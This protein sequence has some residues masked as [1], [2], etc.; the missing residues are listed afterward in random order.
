MQAMQFLFN[1][2][3]GALSVIFILRMWFQYCQV[4]F[5]LPLSQ[6]L[7]KWT[8]PVIKPLSRFLPTV[9]RINLPALLVVFLLGFLKLPLLSFAFDGNNIL[10]YAWVGLLHIASI[11]GETILYILFFGAILSWFNRSDNSLQIILYQLS[12]PLLNPIRRI[13]PHTG[14][15]DFSPMVLAFGLLFLNQVFMQYLPFWYIA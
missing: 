2:L 3:I 13:L 8:N 9:R 12:E 10:L 7:A 1:T 15:L 5:Y 14:M 6:A 4:D 11:W